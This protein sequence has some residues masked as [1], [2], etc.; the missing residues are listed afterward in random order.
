MTDQLGVP[1]SPAE[2]TAKADGADNAAT[3]AGE[4]AH[5]ANTITS[6]EHKKS[7]APLFIGIGV[8][9]AVIVIAIVVLLVVIK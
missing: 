5:V 3:P 9:V 6:P 1:S 2:T 7:K 8:G 4:P